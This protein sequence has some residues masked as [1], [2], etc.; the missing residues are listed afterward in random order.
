MCPLAGLLF[1]L[2][3]DPFLKE[4][5]RRIQ[6]APLGLACACAGD[7]GLPLRSIASLVVVF[8]PTPHR[9]D[10]PRARRFLVL[11]AICICPAIAPHLVQWLDYI[12]AHERSI[13]PC[14]HLW[15]R[16]QAR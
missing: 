3:L 12:L 10:A 13:G 11:L 7:F 4:F 16:W 1:A 5:H 14:F 2:S 15:L 8:D 6:T 9:C